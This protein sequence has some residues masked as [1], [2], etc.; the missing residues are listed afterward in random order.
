MRSQAPEITFNHSVKT[1]ASLQGKLLY[2][3]PP[4]GTQAKDF[5]PQ[6]KKFLNE[7]S[8]S[9]DLPAAANKP[10]VKR[11]ENV[12]DKNFF[13]QVRKQLLPAGQLSS[14]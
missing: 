13:H 12:V 8:E 11:I 4:P 10:K 14:T 7:D 2:C 1:C 3:H 5:Q 9:S 6:H